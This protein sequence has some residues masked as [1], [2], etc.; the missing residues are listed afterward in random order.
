MALAGPGPGNSLPWLIFF[1][2]VSC[3]CFPKTKPN[4]SQRQRGP[5]MQ[6]TELVAQ[7]HVHKDG[8]QI[9]RSKCRL[10]RIGLWCSS[11]EHRFFSLLHCV[12]SNPCPPTVVPW[13][14]TFNVLSS[15]SG[16]NESM[17]PE[18]MGRI[19]WLNIHNHLEQCLVHPSERL[20]ECLE[21]PLT[22]DHP[23]EA[24]RRWDN[25]ERM[26]GKRNIV[27]SF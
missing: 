8:D 13:M 1:H 19:K 4:L 21:L 25:V 6:H 17:Y 5:W 23:L 24:L 11:L 18:I 9:W 2:P 12:W 7:S 20:S 10:F 3:W 27:I 16:Y 26:S 14:S 22:L 15:S